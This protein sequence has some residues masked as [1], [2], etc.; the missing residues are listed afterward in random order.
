[1]NTTDNETKPAGF[2]KEELLTL[3]RMLEEKR[4]RL[5]INSAPS[6]IYRTNAA[7][8]QLQPT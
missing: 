4:M 2:S 8:K 3:I 7:G 6:V 1:M 5:I